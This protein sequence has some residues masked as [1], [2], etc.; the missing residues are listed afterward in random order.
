MKIIAITSPTVVVEEDVAIISG[1]LDG[2][3]DVVHLRKPD[4]DIDDCRDLLRHLDSVYLSR[5]VV[6]DYVELYSEFSLRG[7][8]SNRNVPILP[9]GY[10]GQRSR[11]CHSLDEVVRYKG[12]CDYL[13]LSPIFD[14]ISKQGYSSAFSSDML[15]QAAD[16][17][18]IDEKVIALGGVTFDK[19][20]YLRDLNFGGAAMLGAL[21]SHEG[22]KRLN[23]INQYK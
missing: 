1:L 9:S 4:S 6:H 7:V 19:L 14:S 5:I 20:P 3:V 23:Q 21:Y 22:V 2:G 10:V 18:I 13:F 16:D 11:S 8:H 15:R 17:G 12:E